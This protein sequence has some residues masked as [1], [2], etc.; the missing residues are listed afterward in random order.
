MHLDT[1]HDAFNAV[2]FA[3][4]LLLHGFDNRSP[5]LQQIQIARGIEIGLLLEVGGLEEML[6]GQFPLLIQ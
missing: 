5:L 6:A 2:Y 3:V 1:L 4:C